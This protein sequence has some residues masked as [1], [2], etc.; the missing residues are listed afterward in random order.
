MN[1]IAE[2]EAEC[3]IKFPSLLQ[4]RLYEKQRVFQR[5][6]MIPLSLIDC[7]QFA[8]RKTYDEVTIVSLSDSIRRHGLLQPIIV[9][10]NKCSFFEKPRYTCL[11]GARRLRACQMLSLVRVPCFVVSPRSTD[12]KL[13]SLVENLQRDN[14]SMFES[15]DS[16]L[17]SCMDRCLSA[18]ELAESLS[19][20][21]KIVADLIPFSTVGNDERMSVLE[22]GLSE[23]QVKCLMKIENTSLR[24]KILAYVAERGFGE[25]QTE[26]YVDLLLKSDET[27]HVDFKDSFVNEFV[28]ELSYRVSLLQKK[29]VAVHLEEFEHRGEVQYL[30]RVPKS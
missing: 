8:C 30:I 1:E 16:F 22:N 21:Q 3:W 15:A 20:S 14:L 25:K 27:E 2:K 9:M 26:E 29:G 6:K 17:L 18:A 24:R 12:M 7:N 5:V 11:V 13:L 4:T 28:S 23:R 19:I 10:K